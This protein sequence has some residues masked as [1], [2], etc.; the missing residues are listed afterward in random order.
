MIFFYSNLI[1]P[2]YSKFNLLMRKKLFLFFPFFICFSLQLFA[3]N[4]NNQLDTLT[5]QANDSLAF[6]KISTITDNQEIK[7]TNF[8]MTKSPL[9]AVLRSLAFPGWGQIYVENYWKAPL[10]AAGCGLLVYF[11]LDNNSK[12]QTFQKQYDELKKTSPNSSELF[13]LGRKKEFYRDNRD[14]SAFFLVAVYLLAAIDSYVG[15]H[16]YDF[17][18]DD[19]IALSLSNHIYPSIT[20]K[21]TIK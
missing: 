14:Q 19:K 4:P 11:V 8:Q 1:L 20:L 10:F 6:K 18:V 5:K 9:G 12:Y 7:E 21:I 17:S 13:F 16:L 3:Q 2:S 15:A